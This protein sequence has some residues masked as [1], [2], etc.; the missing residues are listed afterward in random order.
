MASI[1]TDRTTGRRTIQFVGD[2]GKRYSVRFG[3]VSKRQAD[4]AKRFIEDLL[5]SKDTGSSPEPATAQWIA[6]LSDTVRRRLERVGLIKPQERRECPTLAEWV[7]RYID[8]RTDVKANTR[9]LYEQTQGNLLEFYGTTKRF[10][11]ITPGDAM[12]F[13]LSLHSKGLAEGTIRRRCG[14]AKQFFQAAVA[15]EIIAKNPFAGVPCANVSNRDRFHFVSAEEIE[16]VLTACPHVEWQ[17]IFALARYGGLRVPSEVLLLRWADIHWD[18]QRFTVRSPKTAHQ[19]KASRIAPLYP[20]LHAVLLNAFEAAE[21]GSEFVIS[22]Y[23]NTRANL[24]TQA[25]RIIRRAGLEPWEKVF[26]NCRSTRETELLEEFPI[27]T[28]TAW[29]G[30]SP[31]IAARHYLQVTPAHF[32]KAVEKAVQNPVQYDAELPRK[33]SQADQPEEGE[34]C[35]CGS[36]QENAAQC[37]STGP[38]QAPRVGLEPTT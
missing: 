6:G 22:R 11:E 28:V 16:A 25:H 13:R 15:K 26:Q 7:Q 4:C 18:T 31:Q 9:V 37:V 14:R 2:D 30:N 8:S 3:K 27:Q 32:A 17:A 23:R 21:T 1:S 34:P 36:A 35:F 12:E 24:R 20:E 19:G 33:E 29:L 10:D 5:H 38:H